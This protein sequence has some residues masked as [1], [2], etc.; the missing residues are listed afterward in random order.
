MD[1]NERLRRRTRAHADMTLNT[2]TRIDLK[3]HGARSVT[4]IGRMIFDVNTYDNFSFEI[5]GIFFFQW[6]Y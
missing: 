5:I 6:Q 3:T 2:P 4:G 1:V